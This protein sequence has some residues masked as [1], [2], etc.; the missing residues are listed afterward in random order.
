MTSLLLPPQPEPHQDIVDCLA[1]DASRQTSPITVASRPRAELDPPVQSPPRGLWPRCACRSGADDYCRRRRLFLL[2]HVFGGFR[3]T[4]LLAFD[5]LRR[6]EAMQAPYRLGLASPLADATLYVLSVV[7]CTG[8]EKSIP[9]RGNCRPIFLR[10]QPPRSCQKA[11]PAASSFGL[12]K[13]ILRPERRLYAIGW[14]SFKTKKFLGKT[15]ARVTDMRRITV[16]CGE[17]R[18]PLGGN[19]VT[20]VT[21]WE[22][23]GENQEAGETPSNAPRLALSFVF[24][25]CVQGKEGE[26]AGECDGPRGCAI[27]GVVGQARHVAR[28]AL[29]GGPSRTTRWENREVQK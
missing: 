16:P 14:P 2:W 22:I 11:Q 12:S 17:R 21:A 13:S 19:P 24:L 9:S 7:C 5:F 15:L 20:P 29:P 6:F 26:R 3:A 8:P 4:P 28:R 23:R 1:V 18:G 27:N 10:P 25:Q